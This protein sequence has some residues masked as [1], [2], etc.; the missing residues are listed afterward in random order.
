MGFIFIKH[1]LY[2]WF[3]AR[4]FMFVLSFKISQ[5]SKSH[6]IIQSWCTTNT[7]FMEER[8]SNQQG[9]LEAFKFR[10]EETRTHILPLLCVLE[11]QIL[12][13]YYKLGI[14]KLPQDVFVKIKG[15]NAKKKVCF[16]FLSFLSLQVSLLSHTPL[17]LACQLKKSENGKTESSLSDHQGT[18]F[19][20]WTE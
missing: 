11:C 13:F 4:C 12:V 9:W 16:F 15:D 14:I 5:P 20:K 8:H 3:H 1:L 18:S 19:N 6:P 10:I 2:T 7:V 17:L